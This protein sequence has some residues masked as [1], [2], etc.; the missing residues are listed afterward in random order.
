MTLLLSGPLRWLDEGGTEQTLPST[1]PAAVLL[2]LARSGHW[3][4]RAELASLFPG[5]CR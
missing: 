2:V 1:L 4:P 5:G 3:M